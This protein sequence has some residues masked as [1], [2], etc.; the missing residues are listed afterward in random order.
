M[1]RPT[2][3]TE[4]L[5]ARLRWSTTLSEDGLNQQQLETT[6]STDQSLSV[7]CSPLLRVHLL[8]DAT[9]ALLTYALVVSVNTGTAEYTF[10]V[11]HI[12]VH[13]WW[14]S[15]MRHRLFLVKSLVQHHQTRMTLSFPT[16]PSAPPSEPEKCPF[17]NVN[18]SHL[19]AHS[20]GVESQARAR[21][22]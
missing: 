13:D 12:H 11:Q 14:N 18:C 16:V 10:T 1:R 6:I 15:R 21:S 4:V 20:L 22:R 2:V 5:Y 19:T 3:R 7:L 9:H 8:I 17:N